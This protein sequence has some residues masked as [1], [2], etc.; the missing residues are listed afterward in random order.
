MVLTDD[1]FGEVTEGEGDGVR[2]S[3][4]RLQTYVVGAGEKV[5]VKV[6]EEYGG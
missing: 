3:V 2:V 4:A 1:D 6:R 5:T